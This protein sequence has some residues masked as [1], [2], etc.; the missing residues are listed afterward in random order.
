MTD[1]P[2]DRVCSW[3]PRGAHAYILLYKQQDLP[4]LS[5]PPR[6][7]PPR[8]PRTLPPILPTP[9][10][11]SAS[12]RRPRAS[13][14]EQT[15]AQLPPLM[16]RSR[17]PPPQ[18]VTLPPRRRGPEHAVVRFGWR[19]GEPRRYNSIAAFNQAMVRYPDTIANMRDFN[20]GPNMIPDN[21]RAAGSHLYTPVHL[22]PRDQRSAS[23]HHNL[24]DGGAAASQVPTTFAMDTAQRQD[25]EQCQEDERV[26][27]RRLLNIFLD[28][29]HAMDRISPSKT[30]SMFWLFKQALTQAFFV[31]DQG[32]WND[33]CSNLIRR[34][35]DP[36][37]V[38][39]NNRTYFLTRV[40]RYMPPPKELRRRLMAVFN[41]FGNARCSRTNKP[42]FTSETWKCVKK[43]MVHVDRGCLSDPEGNS[44]WNKDD[45]ISN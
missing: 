13:R 21:S 29:F 7:V 20:I 16:P 19:P 43:L 26:E 9:A 12:H 34:G 18:R 17:L 6:Q 32:Y 25:E 11:S 23:I 2:V 38:F 4:P 35:L 36:S 15:R 44:W 33:V 37:T 1:V 42:L 41:K 28:P 45:G 22:R 3:R 5:S 30:H 27:I 24:P 14:G 39:W 10:S 8:P 40:P 31:W